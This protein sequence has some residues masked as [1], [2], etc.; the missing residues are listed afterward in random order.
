MEYCCLLEMGW[1][2]VDFGAA[3]RDLARLTNLGQTE[4]SLATSET[5]DSHVDRLSSVIGERTAMR[6]RLHV[7]M[8]YYGV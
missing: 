7:L 2:I 1:T 5:G 6:S 4:I 3:S 8:E